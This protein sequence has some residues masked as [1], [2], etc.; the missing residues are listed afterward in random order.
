MLLPLI[1]NMGYT[2]YTVTAL[3][4]KGLGGYRFALELVT[5]GKVLDLQPRV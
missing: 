3:I 4:L 2:G 5:G 1:E